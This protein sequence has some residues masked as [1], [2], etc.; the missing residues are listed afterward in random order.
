M[1]V[2]DNFLDSLK[3]IDIVKD[4]EYSF[5][6][7]EDLVYFFIQ[8]FFLQDE[9]K[10]FINFFKNFNFKEYWKDLENYFLLIFRDNLFWKDIIFNFKLSILQ[11]LG[12]KFYKFLKEIFEDK[13]LFLISSKINNN[14][15]YLFIQ[16]IEMDKEQAE[17]YIF[18]IL[19][20][21]YDVRMDY[22]LDTYN[23]KLF[24]YLNVSNL[25]EEDVEEIIKILKRIILNNTNILKDELEPD[26]RNNI[27][28]FFFSD[29]CEN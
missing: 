20:K 1:E 25:K 10:D 27:Y 22:I 16:D 21:I 4:L 19:Q 15:C 6:D 2:K 13:N 9:D 14:P 7:K 5:K 3:S 11:L 26:K 24:D 12:F 23:I 28:I 18:S 29:F 17:S 8:N